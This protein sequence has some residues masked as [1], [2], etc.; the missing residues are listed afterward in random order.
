[1]VRHSVQLAEKLATEKAHLEDRLMR[2]MDQLE[3]ANSSTR[4]VVD[5]P[6]EAATASINKITYESMAEQ[7]KLAQ[8][9]LGRTQGELSQKQ[10]ELDE[11]RR[12]EDRAKVVMDEVQKVSKPFSTSFR[13]SG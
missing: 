3:A 7:V 1:M 8:T 2:L 13:F 5:G 6:S 11:M 12:G 4:V 10:V 9:A